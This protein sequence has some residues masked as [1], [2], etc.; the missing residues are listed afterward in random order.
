MLKLPLKNNALPFSWRAETNSEVVEKFLHRNRVVYQIG[1]NCLWS[2]KDE[3]SRGVGAPFRVT[4]DHRLACR[5]P[6]RVL[7]YPE[8]QRFMDTLA[9]FGVRPM[10]IHRDS[11]NWVFTFWLDVSSKENRAYYR[12]AQDEDNSERG[13]FPSVVCRKLDETIIDNVRTIDQTLHDLIE[14]C[15]I[16]T[17]LLI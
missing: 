11:K 2:F 5:G 15:M 7:L 1:R 9:E 14:E 10:T 12:L 3:M 16:P 4:S 13:L 6:P 17:S 8:T